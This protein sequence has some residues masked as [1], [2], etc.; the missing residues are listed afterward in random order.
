MSARNILL[1]DSLKP[2]IS[3]FGFARLLEVKGESATTK[4]DVGPVKWMVKIF[5]LK[6]NCTRHL[7][8][9]VNC[10]ILKSLMFGHLESLATKLLTDKR[11][12]LI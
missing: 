1:D 12:I 5:K 6:I 2:K 11:H 9:L 8:R 7:N 4:T 3:D 10:N